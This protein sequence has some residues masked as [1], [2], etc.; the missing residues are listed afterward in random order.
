MISLRSTHL[1]LS[2]CFAVPF[3]QGKRV[4]EEGR[5][6]DGA[7]RRSRQ[8]LRICPSRWAIKTVSGAE[9]RNSRWGYKVSGAEGPVSR[10]SRRVSGLARRAAATWRRCDRKISSRSAHPSSPRTTK[11]G[12][13]FI[14]RVGP[15]SCRDRVVA[16]LIR[17]PSP[18]VEGI[19][20]IN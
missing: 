20:I 7:I 18:L 13:I 14:S 1:S 6:G 16:S 5:P 3:P 4:G 12:Q 2:S 10:T 17:E 15:R 8:D 11:P 19:T 9:G